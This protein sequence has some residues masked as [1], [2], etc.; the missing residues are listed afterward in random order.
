M[1]QTIINTRQA[2]GV[3]KLI[4]EAKPL[5]ASGKFWGIGIQVEGSDEYHNATGYSKTEVEGK[6]ANAR[7]GQTVTFD[8]EQN[9]RNYWNVVKITVTKETTTLTD[10]PTET[11]PTTAPETEKTDTVPATPKTAP[12]K[13]TATIPLDIDIESFVTDVMETTNA[14]L[15]R[16]EAKQVYA[17]P[18]VV[19]RVV[20]DIKMRN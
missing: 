1:P 14:I 9:D 20:T 5:G 19:A 3:I 17:T 13:A 10:T 6:V 4:T 18:D 8:E 12:T 15:K 7:V 11:T 2:S 16:L